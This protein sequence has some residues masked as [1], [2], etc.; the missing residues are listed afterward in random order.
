[1]TTTEL[2]EWKF[3]GAIG[4]VVNVVSRLYQ[5]IYASGKGESFKFPVVLPF[6]LFHHPHHSF[7]IVMCVHL[8]CIQGY[9]A[10]YILHYVAVIMSGELSFALLHHVFFRFK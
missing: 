1:M 9:Q 2:R 6:T 8:R 7:E 5:T 10:W 4:R 3:N